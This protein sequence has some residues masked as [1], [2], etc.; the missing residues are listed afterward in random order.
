MLRLLRAASR[1][2]RVIKYLGAKTRLRP[3]LRDMFAASDATTAID[4]FT[5]TTLVAQ[6]M[7]RDGM[8]VTAVDTSRYSELF[9]QT[10]I[11]L[12]SG[13]VDRRELADAIGH[14]GSLDGEPG[15]FTET[16]CKTAR[17]F[18]PDNGARI[19]TIR[20][21][22]ASDYT[23]TWLYPVLMTAL[24]EAADRVDST[25]GFHVSYLKQWAP[26]A[27][28][29]LVLRPPSLI[30]GTGATVR[31]DSTWPA[32]FGQFDL[33]YIDPP[34]NQHRY[35]SYYHIWET[36]VAWDRPE[37][38][39]V[40]Q[41]RAD[42]KDA[43]SKTDLSSKRTYGAA[44]RRALDVDAQVLVIS[45]NDESWMAL[46]DLVDVC[47]DRPHSAVVGF[48]TSRHVGAK[49]GI[50]GPDGTVAGEVGRTENV[51]YL[52]VAGPKDTV[53]R[54]TGPYAGIGPIPKVGGQH[55]MF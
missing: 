15:W 35:H 55:A 37:T 39:G 5:G 43:V 2:R 29:P 18:H 54:M 32:Q 12:D 10:Y 40:A 46:G 17:F 41:K 9:G 11:T 23:G 30:A 51:E 48:E 42:N 7:K 25:L 28:H 45:Y 26:R 16:Y 38:Y 22:I 8:N 6:A 20:A 52:V 31:A 14:L 49:L 21:A 24:I 44:I 53:E 34:Y 19:D 27:L 4:L 33:A 3:V 36:L 47:A 50:N 1:A 13:D